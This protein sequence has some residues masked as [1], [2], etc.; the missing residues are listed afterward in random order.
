LLNNSDFSC[1]LT[2]LFQD[3]P[4]LLSVAAKRLDDE[5]QTRSISTHSPMGLYVQSASA[6]AE[7][8]THAVCP[9]Y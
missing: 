7:Y 5:W 6:N 9:W 2:N 1:T 4:T 8:E 3:C